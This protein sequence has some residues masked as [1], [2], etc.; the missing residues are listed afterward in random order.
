MRSSALGPHFR[1][2]HIYTYLQISSH[3]L[4]AKLLSPLAREL[5]GA[6]SLDT[7]ADT[8]THTHTLRLF[9]ERTSSRK[10]AFVD[11]LVDV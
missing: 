8:H 10:V 7:G 11:G 2:P 1:T 5:G 9:T 6:T 3:T 4:D